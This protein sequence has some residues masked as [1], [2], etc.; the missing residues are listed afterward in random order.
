MPALELCFLMHVLVFVGGSVSMSFSL[1][2]ALGCH[3]DPQQRF[4]GMC[5]MC[6]FHGSRSSLAWPRQ[7]YFMSMFGSWV[8]GSGV[9]TLVLV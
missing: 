5:V 1:L 3:L 9:L 8:V 7:E 6:P 4:L 2:T